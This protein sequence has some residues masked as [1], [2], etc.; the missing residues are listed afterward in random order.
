[1]RAC[2]VSA[3]VQ[4][5][6]GSQLITSTHQPH[7]LFECHT[8]AYVQLIPHAILFLKKKLSK[9]K[10]ILRSD[11]FFCVTLRDTMAITPNS[12][13]VV[14]RFNTS[15]VQKVKVKC[16][17]I[18]NSLPRQIITEMIYLDKRQIRE[19]IENEYET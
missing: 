17:L 19:I 14:F 11:F 12:D 10:Y 5:L 9:R 4:N 3:K 6:C 2:Y 1:M 15:I 8:I 7:M 16:R 13:K 18:C